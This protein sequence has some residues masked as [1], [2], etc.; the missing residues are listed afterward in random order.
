MEGEEL[1]YVTAKVAATIDRRFLW[2]AQTPQVFRT[3]LLLQAFAAAGDRASTFTDD[4]SLVEAA[5]HPV[6]VVECGAVN[7]KLTY[8]EDVPVIEALLQARAE[9]RL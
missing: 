9:G 5:G 6:R 8:P 4:A 3:S 7:V 1:N 2:A